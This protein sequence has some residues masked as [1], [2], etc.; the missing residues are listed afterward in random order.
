MLGTKITTHKADALARLMEQ[1]RN[2]S[3]IEGLYGSF[4]DQIQ[5]LEDA[6]FELNA[7]RQLFDGTTTPA[8]GEQLDQIGTIV[9]ISRNGLSD[10]GYLLFIFGK[11]AANFSDTTVP[12]ILSIIGYVFQAEKVLLQECFP[13]GIC[14]EML[15]SPIDPRLYLVAKDL[16]QAALG[17]SISIVFAGVYPTTA[18]FRFASP[19]T[20]D[21]NGF[22][23]G[24]FINLI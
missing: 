22:G 2:K 19:D 20:T 16:V 1:Y 4:V 3:G 15:G 5:A 21:L 11:I 14:I 17:A 24:V 6:I 9:G 10:A 18:V 7:G 13:A 8:V 12:T 23:Q